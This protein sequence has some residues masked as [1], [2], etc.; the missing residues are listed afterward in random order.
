M[1]PTIYATYAVILVAVVCRETLG[2]DAL[3]GTNYLRTSS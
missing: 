2:Q 3:G 1:T